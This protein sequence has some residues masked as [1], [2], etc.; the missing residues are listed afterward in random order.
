MT[1][2]GEGVLLPIMGARRC[3]PFLLIKNTSGEPPR[4]VGAAPP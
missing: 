1:V 2:S 4:A 3:F